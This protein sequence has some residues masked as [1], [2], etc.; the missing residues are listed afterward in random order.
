MVIGGWGVLFQPA[1]PAGELLIPYLQQAGATATPAEIRESYRLATLGRLSPDELW[2][3]CGLTGEPTWTHGPYT[4]RMSVSAGAADFVRSLLRRRIEVACVTNDVSDWSWRLRAWTGFEALSPWVVSSD[5]GI[6]KPDP[7]VFEMLRR[8][9]EIPFANCLVIDNDVRTLDAARSLGMS[10]G[11]FG[12]PPE[13]PSDA[14]ST[15]LAVG[16]FT[17]LLRR[18]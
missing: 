12:T 17:T 13:G 15:H 8:V 16:D 18:T 14:H 2:E 3:S 4:G 5:I 11:L 9:A 6:R 7:G 1:D 10:T